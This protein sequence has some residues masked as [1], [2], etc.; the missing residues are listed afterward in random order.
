MRDNI[1]EIIDGMCELIQGLSPAE[2]K[3]LSDSI[4]KI[5]KN[6]REVIDQLNRGIDNYIMLDDNPDKH[7]YYVNNLYAKAQLQKLVPPNANIKVD[8]EVQIG[9]IIFVKHY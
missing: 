2:C 4:T 5:N 1:S 6:L 9:N 8:P 3:R 7:V